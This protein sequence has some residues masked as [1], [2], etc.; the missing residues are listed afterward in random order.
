MKPGSSLKVADLLLLSRV[1]TYP[2][3]LP[4]PEELARLAAVPEVPGVTQGLVDLQAEYVRLFINSLPELP[5]PP[6]GSFYLEGTLMGE[7][8]VNLKKLYARFGWHTDELADHFAVELEFLAL[9]AA[10]GDDEPVLAAFQ[11]VWEHLRCWAPDFLARVAA[12]DQSGFYR[13]AARYAQQV[14][15]I[16]PLV[17]P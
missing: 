10:A 4:S 11:E 9:L 8:T 15:G 16:P 5:C 12:H 7:S 14:L 1:F 6:Y 13:Q 3:T 17:V 2:E